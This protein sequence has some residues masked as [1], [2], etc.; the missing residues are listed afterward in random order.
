MQLGPSER[1]RDVD[2]GVLPDGSLRAREAPDEEAVDL[3]L[4]AGL[5]GVDVALGLR[6]VGRRTS[7]RAMNVNTPAPLV[8]PERVPARCA[9]PS[10]LAPQARSP[11]GRA[12]RS[13]PS[14]GPR[15]LAAALWFPDSQGTRSAQRWGWPSVRR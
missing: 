10:G 15:V 5:G 1:G 13:P 8:V 12:R 6:Q 14:H 7:S 9:P 4:L 11:Q 3:D 2:R